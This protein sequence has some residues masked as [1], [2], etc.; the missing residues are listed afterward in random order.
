MST[1]TSCAL[2]SSVSTV[3]DLKSLPSVLMRPLGSC[4]SCIWRWLELC[5]P[6][7]LDVPGPVCGAVTVIVVHQLSC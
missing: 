2:Q 3:W 7:L 4:R 6:W 1:V 5:V